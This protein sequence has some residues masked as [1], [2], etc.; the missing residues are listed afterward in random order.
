MIKLDAI[1]INSK[2]RNKY[3]W[4]ACIDCGKE[5]W[6]FIY[7]GKPRNPRCHRCKLSGNLHPL[8]QGGKTRDNRQYIK[9]HL[10]R[11]DPL[12]PMSYKGEVVE[13]RLVMARHLG[14][15]LHRQEIVHHI[16]GNRE[17][18]RIENLEIVTQS[19]HMLYTKL[20]L[21]CEVRKELASLKELK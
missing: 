1:K 14:R 21:N 15:C 5:R 16:N 3:V 8:W 17:D 2:T 7:K 20:C 10:K 9:V 18:N 12:Y 11:D 6:V 19:S 13:H 4:H